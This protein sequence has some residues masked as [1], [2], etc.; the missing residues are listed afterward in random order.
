MIVAIS[1]H[2]AI[3]WH[4][5]FVALDFNED[6]S[7]SFPEFLCAVVFLEPHARVCA[8]KLTV[9]SP[10]SSRHGVFPTLCGDN[11]VPPRKKLRVAFG[12]FN[13]YKV[14][15][16]DK[17]QILLMLAWLGRVT[18]VLRHRYGVAGYYA[19]NARYR[20]VTSTVAGDADAAFTP[21]IRAL[22]F[23]VLQGEFCCRASVAIGVRV[24]IRFEPLSSIT[25]GR[26]NVCR[27]PGRLHV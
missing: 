19:T 13:Q 14:K 2:A 3:R 5:Y 23:D 25:H 8:A 11:Q 4:R 10:L 12:V 6:G 9:S 17:H 21:R 16:V 18:F 7:I 24:H 15:T 26:F 20:P 22:L 27:G 1:H